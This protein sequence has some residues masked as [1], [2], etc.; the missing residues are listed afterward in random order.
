MEMLTAA[1]TRSHTARDFIAETLNRDYL[2]GEGDVIVEPTDL[3]WID[4]E[5]WTIDGMDPVEWA[6]AMTSE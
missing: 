1:L 6:E 5:G 3:E 2:T 4:G